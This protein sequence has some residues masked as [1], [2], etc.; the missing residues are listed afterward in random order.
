MR[1]G[2]SKVQPYAK[3]FD[4]ALRVAMEA[5]VAERDEKMLELARRK[6]ARQAHPSFEHLLPVHVAAGAAGEDKGKRLWT[7]P[8]GSLSWAQFRFGDLPAEA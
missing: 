7:H 8:E 1:Y 2:L 3:T 6:D 5:P 4:E